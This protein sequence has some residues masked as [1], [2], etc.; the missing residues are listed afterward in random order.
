MNEKGSYGT[1]RLS[2]ED[3][4]QLKNRIIRSARII[5]QNEKQKKYWAIAA[6]IA[7]LLGAFWM[8]QLTTQKEGNELMN[9]AQR[10]ST[11]DMRN[12][13]QVTIRLEDGK[14]VSVDGDSVSIAYSSSGEQIAVGTKEAVRQKCNKGADVGF[15]EL[16]V[17]FG[18]RSQ[19]S[20][21]DGTRV[22]VNA[23]SRLIYPIAFNGDLREVYLEGEAVFDV[24]HHAEKPFI[25]QTQN[26]HIRVL[27]T[28]FNVQSYPSEQHQFVVLKSGS[29]SL[30]HKK[31]IGGKPKKEMLVAPGTKV[32][33]DRESFKVTSSAVDVAD[34]F[35]W[36]EGVLILHNNDLSY[37]M[38]QLSRYYNVDI[39][40]ADEELSHETFSG[41]LDLKDDILNVVDI[42][43]HGSDIDYQLSKNNQIIIRKLKQQPMK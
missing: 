40:I 33:L 38:N 37:I 41:R 4:T 30:S 2:E 34:Y 18:K 29:I 26:Q 21:S 3:K 17:P 32:N 15:N 6:S 10:M 8:Y 7:L 23:G 28:V 43:K 22:W 39:F 42:I 35:S 14:D 24:S 5:R 11:V 12:V 36:M 1:N 31:K 19:V 9:Y 13:Q 20:L 16:V 27:G 25:V